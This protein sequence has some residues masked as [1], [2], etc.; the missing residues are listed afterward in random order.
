MVA[1][2]ADDH[3][4]RRENQRLVA[5]LAGHLRQPASKQFEVIG[6]KRVEPLERDVLDDDR[7]TLVDLAR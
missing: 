6:R 5:R 4:V 2:L 3:V 7:R 1:Q